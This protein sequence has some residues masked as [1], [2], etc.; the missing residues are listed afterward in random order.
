MPER[1][2]RRKFLGKAAAAGVGVVGGLWLPKEV[3]AFPEDQEEADL[4]PKEFDPYRYLAEKLK[5][6]LPEKPRELN[7]SEQWRIEDLIRTH[8][9]LP[10][11]FRHES[12]VLPQSDGLMGKEQHLNRFK[13]DR[14]AYHKKFTRD[15]ITPRPGAFGF[16]T[17]TKEEFMKNPE[18]E[19]LERFYN[20]VPYM[21]T[22]SWKKLLRRGDTKGILELKDWWK[23]RKILVVNP[24]N[25]WGL[26]TAICDAGPAWW[27]GKH[28]G[29]S[30]EVMHGL[31]LYGGSNKERVV[32]LF[33]KDVNGEIPLGPVM[34]FRRSSA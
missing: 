28:F 20:A 17:W 26:V 25:G 32:A 11:S 16:F 21:Y 33:V 4:F 24:E 3:A 31:G 5:E 27:T 12:Q 6:I 34:E 9:G 15:G 7:Y 18:L 2:N 13:G 8:T 14:P 30:P 23:Y 1:I 29:G 19:A 22:Q 10:V